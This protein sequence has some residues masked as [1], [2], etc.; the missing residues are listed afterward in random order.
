MDE[1]YLRGIIMCSQTSVP[2]A[3][4]VVKYVW[5]KPWSKCFEFILFDPVQTIHA[6]NPFKVC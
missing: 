6:F 2:M 5:S 1:L 4:Q 3:G